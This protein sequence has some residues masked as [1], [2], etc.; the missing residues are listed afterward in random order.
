MIFHKWKKMSWWKPNRVD[1]K[2][3]GLRSTKWLRKTKGDKC[4]KYWNLLVLTRTIKTEADKG[5]RWITAIKFF[6]DY[7]RDRKF[8]VRIISRFKKSRKLHRERLCTK[9]LG[10]KD[11]GKVFRE[12]LESA[13]IG[14]TQAEGSKFFGQHMFFYS[15]CLCSTRLK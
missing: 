1:V 4:K 5:I 10:K 2:Y 11:F 9:M 7:K 13:S 6:R 3:L 12:R 8:E 14:I 15:Q